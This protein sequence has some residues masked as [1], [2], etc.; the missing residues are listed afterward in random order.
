M[1]QRS[2]SGSQFFFSPTF[3]CYTSPPFYRGLLLELDYV[4][5]FVDQCKPYARAVIW[6]QLFALLGAKPIQCTR[7]FFPILRQWTESTTI[8]LLAIELL[9][10]AFATTLDCNPTLITAHFEPKSN[11]TSQPAGCSGASPLGPLLQ[12]RMIP[13]MAKPVQLPAK[14]A[15]PRNPS[16]KPGQVAIQS[17]SYGYPAMHSSGGMAIASPSTMRQVPSPTPPSI[18]A[19][20]QGSA[21]PGAE[22]LQQLLDLQSWKHILDQQPAPVKNTIVMTLKVLPHFNEAKFNTQSLAQTIDSWGTD[23]AGNMEMISSLHSTISFLKSNG[24]LRFEDKEAGKKRAGGSPPGE[25]AAKK[26]KKG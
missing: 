9:Y 21:G 23:I 16:G 13:E 26:T 18:P 8:N 25:A 24:V 6:K 11:A 4:S 7:P 10:L 12:P 14:V 2:A 3:Q 5:W 15:I 17:K 19:P 1:E 20:A 22:V